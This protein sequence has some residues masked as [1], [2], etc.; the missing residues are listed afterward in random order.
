MWFSLSLLTII[1][2]AGSD[3][4]SKKG[5]R[6]DDRYSHLRLVIV[7][8]TVMGIHALLYLLFTGMEYSPF[9]IIRYFPVSA[10]YILSMT[11]GYAGLRYIE[12]SVSSPICNSSGAVTAILCFLILG[13]TMEVLQ[14][15]GVTLICLGIF[16]L[17]VLEKRKDYSTRIKTEDDPYRKYRV[18]AIAIV[19]PLLYCIIDG[20]GSFLDAWYLENLMSEAEANIS[21][22]LTFAICALISYLYLK[23]VKKQEFSYL[24]EKDFCASALCETAGQFTYIYAMSDNAIVAAPLIAS[25]SIFSVLMSRIFLKEKLTTSQYF[26]IAMVMAGIVVLGIFD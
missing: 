26:V 5:T 23:V 24:R 8:G 17:S 10:M 7:V 14:L 11:L 19:F 22:E 18:G 12:L 21:Y 9:S 20:M 13:Q 16:L 3:L 25:Y 2:W 6:P 1:A 4:F 15:V